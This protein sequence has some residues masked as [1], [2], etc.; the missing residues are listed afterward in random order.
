MKLLPVYWSREN[1]TIL[2]LLTSNAKRI[3]ATIKKEGGS[4]KA[5]GVISRIEEIEPSTRR[6]TIMKRV[7]EFFG[8]CAI[9]EKFKR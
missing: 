8:V 5:Y 1:Q 7:E 2:H 9:T 6:V 3:I 4:W